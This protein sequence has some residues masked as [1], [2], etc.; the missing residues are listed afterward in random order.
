MVVGPHGCPQDVIGVFQKYADKQDGNDD[1]MLLVAPQAHTLVLVFGSHVVIHD[2]AQDKEQ[3]NLARGVVRKLHKTPCRHEG[4][5]E[6]LGSKED[7][8]R[9]NKELL[10]MLV[11]GA[12]NCGP[13]KRLGE[14]GD[15]RAQDRHAHAVVL[16]DGKS[17]VL[18]DMLVEE[19]LDDFHRVANEGARS[20]DKEFASRRCPSS[21]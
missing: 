9:D 3:E 15:E 19:D 8:R 21:N 13:D 6:G 5:D 18:R 2:V 17:E 11:E 12:Q 16:I 10:R 7:G 20:V 4:K 1:K 14:C